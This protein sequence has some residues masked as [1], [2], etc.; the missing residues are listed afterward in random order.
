MLGVHL[1]VLFSWLLLSFRRL[2][3][4]LYLEHAAGNFVA[5]AVE[6]GV[7]FVE[8]VDLVFGERVLAAV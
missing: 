2:H 3:L 6:H 1:H 5:D 7:E 8:T 4:D